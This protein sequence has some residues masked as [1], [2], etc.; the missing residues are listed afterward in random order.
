[1]TISIGADPEFFLVNYYLPEMDDYGNE[2]SPFIPCVGLVPGTKEEPHDLGD[3]Y[4]CHEDNVTVELG[5]PPTSNPYNFGESITRGMA[6][7]KREFFADEETQ[8]TS[9]A[10][11]KFKSSQLTSPQARTFGCEPDYDAYTNGKVRTVPSTMVEDRWRYAGG[12]VHL[13]GDFNCPP[14]VAAL[15]ADVYISLYLLQLSGFN[16]VTTEEKQRRKWYGQPGI[17]RQKPYGIEYRTFSNTWCS[18]TDKA[19]Y[20]GDAAVR[21]CSI[22][23]T[24]SATKLRGYVRQIDW[25]AIR[26]FLSDPPSLNTERLEKAGM[27]YQEVIKITQE[28]Q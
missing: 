16:G 1:M 28:T 13:G 11:H 10:A 15:F 9:T 8:L 25:L 24:R 12:H 2:I 19:T 6:R 14:F 22:L 23:E 20:M 5:I 27:L 18:S 3:G 21:L 4:F 7:I 26:E 17:F